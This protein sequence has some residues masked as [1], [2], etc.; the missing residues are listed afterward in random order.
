MIYSDIVLENPTIL[1]EIPEDI[2]FF[3][4]HYWPQDF[5]GSAEV[6]KKSGRQFIISPGIHNWARIF[7]YHTDALAN[8]RELTLDGKKNGAIGAI[9]SNW[10]DYGGA[11]LR[12]L[13][14]YSYA[15]AA[16]CAWNVEAANLVS[17]EKNFF[18]NFY[19]TSDP[20]VANVYHLLNKFGQQVTW[21]LLF[22]H[23]FYPLGENLIDLIRRA[24]ELDLSGQEIVEEIGQ[25]KGVVK[26]HADHLDYLSFCADLFAWFG[27][28]GQIQLDLHKISKY[29]LDPKVKES[30]AP[31]Y[32]E[33]LSQLREELNNLKNIYQKLW[34]RTNR[35]ENLQRILALLD[36]LSQYLSIKAEEIKGGDF[37]FNGKMEA[38]F[39]SHPR[40]KESKAEVP[41]IFLRKRFYLDKPPEKA[42]LQAIADSHARIWV[43]GKE[44]GEVLARKSL[45]AW[46]E[47]ERVKAWEVSPYLKKGENVLSVMV[48]NYIPQSSA[49]A[50]IWFEVQ[51][52][53][54]WQ[55]FISSDRYW[56]TSDQKERGWELPSFNDQDWLPAVEVENKW[57]ISR[58]YFG[59]SLPSRIEFYQ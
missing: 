35:P 28:L 31:K 23:P 47:S 54:V 55:K 39:I 57:L 40:A 12:E 53:G 49:A 46:V 45:S 11:N 17:F 20:G 24:T 5:Y 3:D 14:Y 7:P 32:E 6:F 26:D 44:I 56:K 18:K 41:L 13:N 51:V 30:F 15:W 59:R 48:Q 16:D 38:P 4:W 43:N 29:E 22:G 33:K 21:P 58:P 27:R 8:I 1:N 9:T 37:S 52:E 36:R 19:G 25:L 50:N 34:L 42:W 10:G 2:I